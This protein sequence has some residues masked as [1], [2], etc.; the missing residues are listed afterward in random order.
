MVASTLVEVSTFVEKLNLV[1]LYPDWSSFQK[2]VSYQ[3]LDLIVIFNK[4]KERQPDESVLMKDLA[5]MAILIAVRGVNVSKMLNRMGAD[6]VSMVNKLVSDY[7][8]ASN[9][10]KGKVDTITLGRIACLIP[11][12]VAQAMKLTSGRVVGSLGTLPKYLAFPSAPSIIPKSRPELFQSWLQWCLSFDKQINSGKKDY[13]TDQTKVESFGH[14]SWDSLLFTEEQRVKILENVESLS[15]VSKTIE[16]HAPSLI[17]R[18]LGFFKKST[19]VP[20]TEKKPIATPKKVTP[21]RPP[22]E[23]KQEEEDEEEE[24]EEVEEEEEEEEV[25]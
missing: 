9:F 3:G 8:I 20:S 25:D 14:I 24:E 23:E 18:T 1:D 21:R 15:S 6:G 19:E 17:D 11:N 2:A 7:S 12:L 4:M 22:P 10:Q 5:M 13:V 16:V